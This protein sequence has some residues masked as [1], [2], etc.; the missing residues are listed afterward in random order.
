MTNEKQSIKFSLF[1][2]FHYLRTDYLNTLG[3]LQGILDRAHEN[4]AELVIQAGDFCQNRVE[5]PELDETF[6][7]NT[8][9]LPVY[10]IYGNH[11]MEHHMSDGANNMGYITPLLT[12]NTSVVWGTAD[13]K[14]GDGS[15]AYYYFEK[16]GF[17]IVCLDSNYSWNA[18]KECWE[19]NLPA[20]WGAPA[21]NEK[22]N[23]LGPRQIEWLDDVL[24]DAASKQMQCIIVSHE[25]FSTL[26]NNSPDSERVREI[27]GKVNGIHRGTVL[28]AI[29]GHWHTHNV[30]IE[31]NVF[32]LQMNT[33]RCAAESYA[34]R[35][36]PTHYPDDMTYEVFAGYDEDGE[37]IFKTQS[38]NC[39]ERSNSTWFFADALNAIITVTHD[40]K[41]TM[42][43]METDWLGGVL[44][45]EP[46]MYMKPYVMS[47]EWQLEV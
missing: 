16:N 45:P 46:T 13:G 3:D 5:S 47:G 7:N 17:R 33:S 30:K 42:E 12:N 8:Y 35:D 6:L 14:I 31:D 19:H 39:A 40:G 15:I 41:I 24:T 29:N 36:R 37:K 21:G 32:Y 1:S 10:G 4:G 27:F 38:V 23:A 11:D 34:N 44:P 18:S 22:V 20:S 43:G 9:G 26:G 2:D 28:M 25:G